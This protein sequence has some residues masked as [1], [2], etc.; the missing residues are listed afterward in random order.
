MERDAG[1][2]TPPHPPLVPKWK[3]KEPCLTQC[4]SSERCEASTAG[5][6]M[7]FQMFDEAYRADVVI[8][9]D[10]GSVIYAHASILVSSSSYFQL[11]EIIR[12]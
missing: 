3:T 12:K 7:W 6:D 2:A 10:Q 1:E 9:T 5:R 8:T 11:Q 4:K